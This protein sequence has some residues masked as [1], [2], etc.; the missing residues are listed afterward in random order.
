[1][2]AA[3]NQANFDGKRKIT[4]YSCHRGYTRPATTPL[5]AVT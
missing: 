3:I 2:M 4:C 1:M 5:I